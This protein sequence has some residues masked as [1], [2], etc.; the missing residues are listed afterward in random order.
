MRPVI[1][2]A[3]AEARCELENKVIDLQS[4]H[5]FLPGKSPISMSMSM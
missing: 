3:G 2:F 5:A 1:V 4:G